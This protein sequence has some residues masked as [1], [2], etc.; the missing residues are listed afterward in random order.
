MS[1]LLRGGLPVRQRILDTVVPEAGVSW[2]SGEPIKEIVIAG[3]AA[4]ASGVDIQIVA[5]AD[6]HD[7]VQQLH[8]AARH[9]HCVAGGLI[10]GVVEHLGRAGPK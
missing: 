6:P 3:K 7:V 1:V 8:V 5:G 2:A 9:V 10:H 4:L